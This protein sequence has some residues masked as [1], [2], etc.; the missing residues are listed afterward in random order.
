[1][2][3][4]YIPDSIN[5]VQ[6]RHDQGSECLAH[7]RFVGGQ[8]CDT[9]RAADCARCMHGDPG[10]IRRLVSAAAVDRYRRETAEAFARHKT[11]FVSDFLKRQ[12]LRAV[13]D[14]EL[15]KAH[16]IHNF[17]DFARLHRLAPG[18]ADIERG[19]VLLA[20][21]IDQAKGFDAFLAAA[22]GR[23]P[24]GAII[25]IVGDG[26]DKGRLE[27]DYAHPQIIFHGWQPYDEVVRM[28]SRSHVC[29]VPSI[30]QEPCGTTILEALALG[31][32]CIA[33]AR[34][35]TPELMRYQRYPGQLVLVDDMHALVAESF[36]RALQE[37]PPMSM[38][39]SME[40]DVNV[41]LRQIL[42]VYFG[43]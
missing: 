23:I 20:G 3:G 5:F 11:I 29:V 7:V 2:V 40:A 16:V 25:N 26:P 9:T 43:Q 33:L 10:P 41:A 8:V 34:G 21:R 32:P 19:T 13:P 35:G 4:R 31:R 15:S 37:T 36:S 18:A 38:L 24:Q 12:F 39:E 14:A 1:M 42:D 17:I 30:W 28:T 22:A 27:R 6:T